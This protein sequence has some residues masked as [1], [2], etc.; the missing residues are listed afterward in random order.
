MEIYRDVG[1]VA[2]ERR[3]ERLGNLLVFEKNSWYA[4]LALGYNG[5]DQQ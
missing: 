1:T 5:T 3:W 4:G 2:T